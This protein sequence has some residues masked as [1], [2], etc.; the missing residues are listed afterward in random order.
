MDQ[1]CYD[2]YYDGYQPPTIPTCQIVLQTRLQV[3]KMALQSLV[4]MCMCM[5]ACVLYICVC[6]YVWSVHR[7]ICNTFPRAGG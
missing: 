7:L 5:H 1:Y 2:A 4:C 3:A 6:M